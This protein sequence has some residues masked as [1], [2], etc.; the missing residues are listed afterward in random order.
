MSTTV[1]VTTPSP[2]PPGSKL[3]SILSIISLVLQALTAIPGLGVPIA[4]EQAF[5]KILTN[6]LAAYQAETGA[7]IDLSKVPQEALVP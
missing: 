5:Q 7:P 2:N 4:I 1:T 6:A 3:Q